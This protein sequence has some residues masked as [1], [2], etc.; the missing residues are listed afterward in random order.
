MSRLLLQAEGTS[1]RGA[2]VPNA[3]LIL[4]KGPSACESLLQLRQPSDTFVLTPQWPL[5]RFQSCS[6]RQSRKTARKRSV[7]LRREFPKDLQVLQTKAIAPCLT[8]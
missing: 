4:D 5:S 8:H 2:R 1:T 6:G 3:A 7:I